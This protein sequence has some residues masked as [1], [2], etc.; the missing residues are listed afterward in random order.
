[1]APNAIAPTYDLLADNFCKDLWLTD[2]GDDDADDVVSVS[3]CPSLDAAGDTVPCSTSLGNC[4]GQL[5]ESTVSES[6]SSVPMDEEEQ[7]EPQPYTVTKMNRLSTTTYNQQQQQ[8]QPPYG[9]GLRQQRRRQ[10]QTLFVFEF[11]PT[12]EQSYSSFGKRRMVSQESD[13]DISTVSLDHRLLFPED[14]YDEDVFNDEFNVDN[15]IDDYRQVEND[16]DTTICSCNYAD[17]ESDGR[18]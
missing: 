10:E 1:M 16:C 5:E 15:V 2:C 3:L 7:Q 8:Q 9:D 17:N 18:Y 14:E 13:S 11:P 12:W 6:I 4:K